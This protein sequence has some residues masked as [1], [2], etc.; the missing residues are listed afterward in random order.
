[1][2]REGWVVSILTIRQ[3][4]VIE[5]IARQLGIQISELEASGGEVRV[6]GAFERTE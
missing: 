1:M 2:G 4:F 6:K 5:K 3:V